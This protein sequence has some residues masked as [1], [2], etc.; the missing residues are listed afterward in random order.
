MLRRRGYEDGWLR[1]PFGDYSW[2]PRDNSAAAAASYVKGKLDWRRRRRSGAQ[3]S[4]SVATHVH[5]LPACWQTFIRPVQEICR[6]QLCILIR[7]WGWF[8]KCLGLRI[9]FLLVS[10]FCFGHCFKNSNGRRNGAHI[11][12]WSLHPFL[13]ADSLL[14]STWNLSRTLMS[15]NNRQSELQDVWAVG[16]FYFGLFCWAQWIFSYF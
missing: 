2:R 4:H 14:S 11:C 8:I 1:S 9:S 16:Q 7:E 13:P 10:S 3:H 12:S 6:E 5:S 15:A